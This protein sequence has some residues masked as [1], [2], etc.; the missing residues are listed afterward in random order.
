MRH[1]KCEQSCQWFVPKNL[2]KSSK[3]TAQQAL[4]AALPARGLSSSAASAGESVSALKA[5][6]NTEI[7]M[8]TANC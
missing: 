2:L 7:A 8:V 1:W 5:E 3:R 4:L 6:I